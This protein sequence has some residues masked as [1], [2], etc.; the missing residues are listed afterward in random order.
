MEEQNP[1]DNLQD[2]KEK[3]LEQFKK[4]RPNFSQWKPIV[5]IVLGV[6]VIYQ[7]F[8]SFYQVEPGER[9][10]VLRYGQ[11]QV[12]TEPGLNFRIPIIERVIIVNIDNIRKEEFGFRSTTS[13]RFGGDARTSRTL[14]V[15]SLMLTGDRNVINLNWVVQ[16]RITEPEKFLFNIK[17]VRATV[18]DI[19]ETVIRRL[20]GN[21]DFDYV[22]DQ[23]EELALETRLEMQK[24]LVRY[25]SGVQLVTIQLQ[26]VTP[27]QAVRPSFN[28]VNEADQDKARLVNEAQKTYNEKIPKAR[29]QA[30]QSIEEAKGYAV[31]RV[32]EAKGD[33]ARFNSIYKEY[34]QYRDVTKTRIY[35]EA[36]RKVLPRVKEIVVIDKNN[37]V[38]PLLNLGK[39]N[40]LNN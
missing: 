7:A 11:Y 32:N 23:R 12:T 2:K 34:R 39:V 21:R 4:N 18:R 22:L 17:D 28:E 36:L 35:T 38:L 6:V 37:N 5:L 16:Y 26:D 33:V 24:M 10:V 8:Q 9:G 20:V 40:S 3:V 19:S 25:Q 31:K 30:K 15:E 14:D 13:A 29:G 27:P 1:W